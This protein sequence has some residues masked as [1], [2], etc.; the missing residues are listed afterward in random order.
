MRLVRVLEVTDGGTESVEKYHGSCT[1]G[2]G[3]CPDILA[4]RPTPH[5]PPCKL[6]LRGVV[7]VDSKEVGIG[8]ELAGG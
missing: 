1:G 5:A 7:L 8:E 4:H 2:K 3:L 6:V